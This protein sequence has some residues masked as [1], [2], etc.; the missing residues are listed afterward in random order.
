MVVGEEEEGENK[1]GMMSC[2]SYQCVSRECPVPLHRG[3]SRMI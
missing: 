3:I 2:L 1:E